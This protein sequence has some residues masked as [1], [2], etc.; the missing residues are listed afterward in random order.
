MPF[1]LSGSPSTFS[2]VMDATLLG[3]KDVECLVYLDDILMYSPTINDRVRRLRLVF[4]RIRDANFKLKA[5]KCKYAAPQVA[6]LGQTRS[7]A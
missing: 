5:E 2:K 1:G 3:L 4:H 6:Y 7:C